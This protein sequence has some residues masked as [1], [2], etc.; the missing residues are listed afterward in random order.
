MDLFEYILETMNYNLYTEDYLYESIDVKKIGSDI[1]GYIKRFFKWIRTK[2]NQIVSKFKKTDYVAD[3]ENRSREVVNDLMRKQYETAK[4]KEEIIKNLNKVKKYD[5]AEIYKWVMDARDILVKQMTN[6]LDVTDPDIMKE[7]ISKF[8][9]S[10]NEL[11]DKEF[12]KKEYADINTFKKESDD[13]IKVIE[14]VINDMS[15]ITEKLAKK[16]EQSGSDPSIIQKYTNAQLRIFKK[17]MS[18]LN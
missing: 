14:K 4:E 16:L 5:Y 13:V 6:S 8:D 2:F 10:I 18:T 17:A 15:S 11:C 12:P 7:S 1:V 3:V 9:E